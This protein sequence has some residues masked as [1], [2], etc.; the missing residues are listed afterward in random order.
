MQGE[1]AQSNHRVS[2][3]GETRVVVYPGGTLSQRS[4]DL[5]FVS[6]SSG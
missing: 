3:G 4:A 6:F 5:F 1:F 2:I